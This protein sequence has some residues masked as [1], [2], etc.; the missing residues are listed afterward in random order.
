MSRLTLT[1]WLMTLSLPQLEKV[2]QV[3]QRKA[4]EKAAEKRR[5]MAAP[6]RSTNDIQE[7]AAMQGLDISGLMREI[8]RR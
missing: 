2:E 8:K 5:L 1:E 7:L 4:E 6:P 3:V